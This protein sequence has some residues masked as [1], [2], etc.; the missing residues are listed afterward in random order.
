MFSSILIRNVNVMLIMFTSGRVIFG[1][2]V[3]KRLKLEVGYTALHEFA[4]HYSGTLQI[5]LV[6]I[7]CSTKHVYNNYDKYN[8]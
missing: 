6:N 1:I 8:V 7:Q 2:S 3:I 4:T 5:L